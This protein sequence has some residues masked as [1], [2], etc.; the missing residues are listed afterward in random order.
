MLLYAISKAK[1]RKV[2]ANILNIIG[3][4]FGFESMVLKRENMTATAT[5]ESNHPISTSIKNKNCPRYVFSL[6]DIAF[7]TQTVIQKVHKMPLAIIIADIFPK[8]KWTFS[9]L[10]I[11]LTFH[12][13]VAIQIRIPAP[14][15][16]IPLKT[17]SEK[18]ID[19][20]ISKLT[21]AITVSTNIAQKIIRRL[22]KKPDCKISVKVAVKTGP[23][24]TPP[25][26]PRIN[27]FVISLLI[28][29]FPINLRIILALNI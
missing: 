29:V 3:T 24:I 7:G 25:I 15:N 5:V 23:G 22:L 19:E 20:R 16:D 18:P 1:Y 11:I 13:E 28:S 6:S 21:N 12:I 2:N 27:A 4:T 17:A 14:I 10:S 26:K 8:L 9:S